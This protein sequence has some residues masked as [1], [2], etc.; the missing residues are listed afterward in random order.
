MY[1]PA[2]RPAIARTTRR[3]ALLVAL[4][5]LLA[6]CAGHRGEDGGPG[7]N[8][9]SGKD[10]TPSAAKRWQPRPGTSRQWQLSGRLDTSVRA[11]VYDIDGFDHSGAT[12]AQLH[13]KGRRVVCYVSTGMAV[14]LKNDLEQ[15]PQLVGGFDFAAG[16][17]WVLR[18]C[19]GL[20]SGEESNSCEAGQERSFA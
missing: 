20:Q 15:I 17:T 2:H 7:G 12:V 19:P 18:G 6:G 10:A 9:G 14:G 8:G 16:F 5:L 11:E 4:L 3:P 13:R 1:V